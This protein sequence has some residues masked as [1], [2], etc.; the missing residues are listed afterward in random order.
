[1]RIDLLPGF[2]AAAQ[3]EDG[4][5]LLPCLAGALHRFTHQVSREERVVIYARQDQWAM[6]SN[7]NCIGMQRPSTAWCAIVTAG[8]FDAEAVIRSHYEEEASYSVHAGLVYRWEPENALLPGDRTVRFQ[9]SAAGS[10]RGAALRCLAWGALPFIEVSARTAKEAHSMPTYNQVAEFARAGWELCCAEYG[11]L[12]EQDLEN[13][14]V[15]APDVTRTTFGN[16]TVLLVNATD[17]PAAVD[18][19]TV[20]ALGVVRRG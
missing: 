3:G 13:V 9:R 14:E 20:P 6:R 19:V 7:F 1:M 15:L 16:G 2:A 17:A 5:L 8:E 4:Y 18:G 11:D 12:V 10:G